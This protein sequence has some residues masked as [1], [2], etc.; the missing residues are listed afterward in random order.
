MKLKMKKAGHPLHKPIRIHISNPYLSIFI[1]GLTPAFKI[2]ILARNARKPVKLNIGKYS[3]FDPP[4]GTG[5]PST[6]CQS[7]KA[8]KPFFF[9]HFI[10]FPL[11]WFGAFFTHKNPQFM[12]VFPKCKSLNKSQS[13][14][15]TCQSL[16]R[17]LGSY[18]ICE[19]F[20]FQRHRRRSILIL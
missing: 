4:G 17:H 19:D 18:G 3:D 5:E 11:L 6:I 10:Y 12:N 7:L 8:A 16:P 2:K 20:R 14:S 9:N 1:R 15:A 13:G